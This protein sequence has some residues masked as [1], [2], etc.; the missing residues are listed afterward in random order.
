MPH[1]IFSTSLSKL[2]VLFSRDTHSP[3]AFHVEHAEV[4][5]KDVTVQTSLAGERVG[6][7]YWHSWFLEAGSQGG[8]HLGE[9]R[10]SYG[11]VTCH[12]TRP[13]TCGAVRLSQAFMLCWDAGVRRCLRGCQGEPEVGGCWGW[14]DYELRRPNTR[15]GKWE[16]EALC[17]LLTINRLYQG[18]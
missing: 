2:C 7:R 5:Q 3:A 6:G 14:G 1:F 13:L 18:M 8:L 4:L 12:G 11:R 15:L 9:R 17:H 10:Q 16:S